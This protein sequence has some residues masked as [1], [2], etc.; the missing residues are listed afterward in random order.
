M[1]MSVNQRQLIS[2][3]A[4]ALDKSETDFMLDAATSEA[5]RVLTDRRWFTVDED[6]WNRF[7]EL[8]DAKIPYE[9]DLRELLNRPT[10]FGQ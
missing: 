6:A 8:L 4:S 7:Q 2:R 1:R 5:E 10:V 9:D 3:A